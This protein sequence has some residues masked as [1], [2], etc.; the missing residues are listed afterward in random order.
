[1]FS[2][3]LYLCN[4]I[5]RGDAKSPIVPLLPFARDLQHHQREQDLPLG[6]SLL[7]KPR[8][9]SLDTP[10]S[11]LPITLSPSG[12]FI[13]AG[14]SGT[15][16]F[17][18]L[19]KGPVGGGEESGKVAGNVAMIQERQNKLER[20]LQQQTS[21]VND[22]VVA[23]PSP[24][25]ETSTSPLIPSKSD[26]FNFAS[27]NS[28]LFLDDDQQ[29]HPLDMP[30]NKETQRHLLY[31]T[32]FPIGNA[33][34][35]RQELNKR[36]VVLYGVGRSRSKVEKAVKKVSSDVEHYFKQL[37]VVQTPVL[38]DSPF[39]LEELMKQ[40]RGLPSFEQSVVASSCEAM[41]RASLM[42]APH[43]GV[44][45]DTTPQFPACAQ[46]VLVCELLETAGCIRQMLDLIVDVVACD[47]T[48]ENEGA[49][50]PLQSSL[51]PVPPLPRDLCL[52]VACLLHKYLLCL[53][54]SQNNTTIVFERQGTDLY[55]Y[56]YCCVF[57]HFCVC[58]CWCLCV[59]VSL[60]VCVLFS[61]LGCV[62]SLMV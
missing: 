29:P 9:D 20:L 6:L 53:L 37:L 1:M 17:D 16:S 59:C 15:F 2:Y 19:M 47:A 39:K 11:S 27:P 3:S 46:L 61:N 33:H 54:L 5:A 51:L 4:L 41:L 34:L 14:Q 13:I 38:P 44:G 31:S 55:I 57:V 62:R 23:F 18:E 28:T 45:G 25:N 42:T 49:E 21:S 50:L 32:Y 22:P 48:S 7:K 56:M 10:M 36:A 8:M 60:Y 30:I 43:D 40:F 52:P 35:S 58:V 26:P 12:S 24:T